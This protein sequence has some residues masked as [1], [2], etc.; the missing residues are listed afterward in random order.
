MINTFQL[1]FAFFFANASM[2]DIV[3]SETTHYFGTRTC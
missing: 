3:H 2:Y 1:A